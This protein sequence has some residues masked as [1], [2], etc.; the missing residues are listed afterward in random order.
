MVVGRRVTLVESLIVCVDL[1]IIKLCGLGRFLAHDTSS[2]G[3]MVYV[4]ME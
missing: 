1:Y 4:C 2:E 3:A